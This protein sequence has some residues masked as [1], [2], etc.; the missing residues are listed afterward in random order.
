MSIPDYQLQSLAGDNYAKKRVKA[1]QHKQYET[2][3]RRT[4][5]SGKINDDIKTISTGI[6]E[7]LQLQLTTINVAEATASIIDTTEYNQK[8]GESVEGSYE[9]G[10]GESIEGSDEERDSDDDTFTTDDVTEYETVKNNPYST[11]LT[12]QGIIGG[13]SKL[14][15]LS[16]QLVFLFT[17]LGEIKKGS[18]P[19][20]DYPRIST[21]L[22]TVDKAY[23]NYGVS[24]FLL[25][26][27]EVV[28]ER[29][30]AGLKVPETD[31]LMDMYELKM[32][33]CRDMLLALEGN[34]Y[35]QK[36]EGVFLSDDVDKKFFIDRKM[37][38]MLLSLKKDGF[39]R[40]D[41]F[42]IATG[43]KSEVF[44]RLG[45]DKPDD[46]ST[47]GSYSSGSGSDSDDDSASMFS[48]GSQQS[49][50]ASQQSGHHSHSSHGTQ[51]SAVSGNG[52]YGGVLYTIPQ[53]QK[54]HGRFPLRYY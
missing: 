53:H 46:D 16:Y 20:I 47:L 52:L 7:N 13:F 6:I 29:E 40:G 23:G 34:V 9:E 38:E 27:S 10:E 3:E 37:Y 43:A 42:S 26:L 49:G 15:G 50:H 14:V 21:A 25:R 31:R 51:A 18:S 8:E 54:I 30:R 12:T 2:E 45:L 35:N 39:L 1:K 28:E 4:Q 22:N 44:R 24:G 33:E 17:K 19:A 48:Q 11:N 5:V 32:E 36:L 41:D